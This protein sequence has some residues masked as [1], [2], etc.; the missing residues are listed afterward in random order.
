MLTV[1]EL[2]RSIKEDCE[3]IIKSGQHKALRKSPAELY[4]LALKI[5][6]ETETLA[7]LIEQEKGD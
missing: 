6:Q 3:T 2:C 4:R 7:A 5:N 1:Q